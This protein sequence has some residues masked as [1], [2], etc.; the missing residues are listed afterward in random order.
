VPLSHALPCLSCG[1]HVCASPALPRIAY[2]APSRS[3]RMCMST[4]VLT[5]TRART[6]TQGV[7]CN[8]TSNLITALRGQAGDGSALGEQVTAVAG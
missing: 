4:R 2:L 6:H 5:H 3:D 1:P 8:P 7:E